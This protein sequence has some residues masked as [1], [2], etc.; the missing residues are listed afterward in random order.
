MLKRIW[1]KI[2]NRKKY[3]L[4]EEFDILMRQKFNTNRLWLYHKNIWIEDLFKKDFYGNPYLLVGLGCAASPQG[5]WGGGFDSIILPMIVFLINDKYEILDFYTFFGCDSKLKEVEIP[6]SS[7]KKLK[8]TRANKNKIDIL[9]RIIHLFNK[10]NLVKILKRPYYG[11]DYAGN[12]DFAKWLNY[13]KRDWI[14]KVTMNFLEHGESFVKEIS[15]IIN[16]TQVQ[17]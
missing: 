10:Y 16:C 15:E 2:R 14:N 4:P 3:Q 13:R 8:L 1:S 9:F 11:I 5:D 17:G 12:I 6:Y 7:L